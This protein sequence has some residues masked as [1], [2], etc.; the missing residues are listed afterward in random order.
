MTPFKITCS[1]VQNIIWN[2]LFHTVKI[3]PLQKSS[4]VMAYYLVYFCAFIN[5]V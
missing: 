1:V 2:N 5:K 3:S 4:L